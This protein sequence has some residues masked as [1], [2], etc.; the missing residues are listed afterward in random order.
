MALRMR[1]ACGVLAALGLAGAV[2][3]GAAGGQA[4]QRVSGT[5]EPQFGMAIAGDGRVLGSSSTIPVSI[6][7]EVVGG[8]EIV[9]VVPK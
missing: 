1:T 9:T 5:V 4:A 6:T 3:P 2:V 8:V 7:R